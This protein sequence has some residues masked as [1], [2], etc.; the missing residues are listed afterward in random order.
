MLEMIFTLLRR[1][2]HANIIAINA[3]VKNNNPGIY[4]FE[5]KLRQIATDKRTNAI[6]K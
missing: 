2:C 5:I 4:L 6:L 3:L 1:Y